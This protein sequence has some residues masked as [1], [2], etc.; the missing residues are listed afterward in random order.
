MKILD[1]CC[2]GKMF[3]YEKDLDFVTFQDVRAGVKEYSGGRKIRIEPNHVGNVTDMDFEDETFDLV[4]FDPPHMIR[5]GKT[6]WLN[7]KYGKLPENWETFFKNAFSEIFRVLKENGVLIF[8]WNETQL[9]FGEVIKHSPYRPMLGDQR[10]QTRWTVFVKNT[11]L[12]HRKE[13]IYC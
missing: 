7:I 8:K 11:A 4:I 1:T 2:G 3:W 10:G 6:S 13:E 9:K 5:A 12:H